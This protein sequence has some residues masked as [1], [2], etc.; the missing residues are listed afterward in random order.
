MQLV[1]WNYG[2]GSG[3]YTKVDDLKLKSDFKIPIDLQPSVILG[4][5]YPIKKFKKN[6]KDRISI[7]KL[8]YQEIYGESLNLSSELLT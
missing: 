1:A 7:D 6:K 5:G 4:F 8:V 3:L 2:I